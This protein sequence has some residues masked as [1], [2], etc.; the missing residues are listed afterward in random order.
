MLPDEDSHLLSTLYIE[1]KQKEKEKT[2]QTLLA[3]S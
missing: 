3:K 2:I 1:D